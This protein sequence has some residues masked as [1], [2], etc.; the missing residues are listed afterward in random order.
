MARLTGPPCRLRIYC[1]TELILFRTRPDRRW[2][3]TSPAFGRRS[4]N[5]RSRDWIIIFLILAEIRSASPVCIPACKDCLAGNFPLPTCSPIQPFV[6]WRD[7]LIRAEKQIM[8]EAPNWIVPGCNVQC[9]RQNGKYV[10]MK[11]FNQTL[12]QELY[13]ESNRG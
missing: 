11:S 8:T 13:H 4:Y 12:K 6:L 7:I 5:C 2:N 9:F 1:T 10:P 3:R